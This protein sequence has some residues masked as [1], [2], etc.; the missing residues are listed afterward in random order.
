MHLSASGARLGLVGPSFNTP[1]DVA[2]SADS[3][4]VLETGTSGRVRRIAR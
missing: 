4:Y 1:F 3:V 2:V